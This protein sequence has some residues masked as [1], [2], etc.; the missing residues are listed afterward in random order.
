MAKLALIDSHVHIHDCF[1]CND[2]F[3]RAYFNFSQT[4]HRLGQVGSFL[5][6]LM[7]TE[8]SQKHYFERFALEADLP[9][10]MKDGA[11]SGSWSFRRT[12]ESCSLLAVKED[13]VLVLIAG[14]Q[15]NAAENL[16]LLILGTEETFRDG[17]P[18]ETVL[19]QAI[20]IDALHV[21]PWGAGKWFF[22]RGRLLSKLIKCRPKNG[23]YLADQGGRPLL[24]PA[25]RHMRWAEENGIRVLSGSDPL[26]F[27]EEI[28]RTGSF[29]FS[30]QAD[31][32][33]SKPAESIKTNLRRPSVKLTRFGRLQ[34]PT[35]FLQNQIRMQILKRRRPL[36]PA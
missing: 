3:D 27:P 14:R 7:L 31:V 23:F 26:P 29:G 5:G 10:E 12:K 36:L 33:L 21:I 25:P 9:D 34:S 4:A 32:D 30:L 1:D 20:S 15:V 28:Q 35:R 16:E 2:L 11:S 17:L 6:V 8:T 22:R 18:I 24:W 19:R 13:A